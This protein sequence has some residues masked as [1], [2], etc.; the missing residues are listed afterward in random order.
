MRKLILRTL[1]DILLRFLILLDVMVNRLF[2]GRMET[3]SSRAG[4]ARASGRTWG[5]VLCRWL[6]DLDPGHCDDAMKSPL[7][8]LE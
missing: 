2:N 3:I 4:R 1:R 5:C 6:E 7:G 8:R